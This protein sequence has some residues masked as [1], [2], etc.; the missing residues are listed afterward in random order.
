MLFCCELLTNIRGDNTLIVCGFLLK[1]E[2]NLTI[3]SNIIDK[4]MC[5]GLSIVLRI[6]NALSRICIVFAALK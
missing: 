1:S 3:E 5:T 2:I 4:Y 6:L